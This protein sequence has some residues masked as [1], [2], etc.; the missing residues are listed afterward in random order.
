MPEELELAS[1][2]LPAALEALDAAVVALLAVA[3]LIAVL[4]SVVSALCAPEMSLLDS[5]VETLAR[6]FPSGLL[7]SEF[8]GSSCSTWARYFLALVVSPELIADNSPVSAVSNG[9]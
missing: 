6:N 2:L 7:E 3:L 1:E 8:E 9:F 4:S 5:A